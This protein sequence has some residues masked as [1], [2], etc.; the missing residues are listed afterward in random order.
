[1]ELNGKDLRVGIIGCGLIG[2]RRAANLGLACLV[3]CA[4]TD[5][6]KARALAGKYPGATATDDWR[7]VIDDRAIDAVIVATTHDMLA[8]ITMAAVERGK[9]VLVEKPAARR[10][11]ELKPIIDAA[12]RTG[13]SVRIGFNHR[14]HPALREA[15]RIAGSGALGELLYIRGRYGHGGRVGYE[16]E[17]R[18]DPARSGGGELLDQG[19]HLIDLSRWFLGDFKSVR[20]SLHT[21]F[22]KMPVEDNAFMLLETARRQTA[23]LHVSWTEWKNLFCLEI[24]GC[25]GKLQIDGLG[26][27]YGTEKLTWYR[28]KPEM[29]PP[30]STVQEFAAQDLSW[31]QEFE[32]FVDDIRLK[33]VPVP[34]LVD[35]CAVL[36]LVGK[37]YAER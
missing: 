6:A 5:S 36:E 10:A 26:G 14:Y 25:D 24:F 4:D 11:D 13:S 7:A 35:A 32:E 22:W 29:G 1:M 30:E 17:W 37:I 34:G 2:N 16:Q 3:M 8:P 27:S 18:A 21:Y 31:Q 12:R 19:V 23:F 9:H 28:M 20:G 33:R 15:R